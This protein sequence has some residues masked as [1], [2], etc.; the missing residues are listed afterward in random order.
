MILSSLRRMEISNLSSWFIWKSPAWRVSLF[1]FTCL[2]SCAFRRVLVISVSTI[3]G[4]PL[5]FFAAHG[6]ARNSHIISDHAHVYAR[7]L[8]AKTGSAWPKPLGQASSRGRLGIAFLQCGGRLLCASAQ[9]RHAA[10]MRPRDRPKRLS[11]GSLAN[12][13]AVQCRSFHIRVFADCSVGLFFAGK[14]SGADARRDVVGYRLA[15]ILQFGRPLSPPAADPR[16]DRLQFLHRSDAAEKPK[17]R[18]FGNR[19]RWRS[20]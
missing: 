10:R 13:H 4:I 14:A 11:G 12:R 8:L 16:V 15:R 20:I 19:R 2:P 3:S 17:S 6:S 1:Q 5:S 9:T 18:P 7:T